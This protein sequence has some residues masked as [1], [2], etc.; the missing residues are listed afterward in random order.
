[1]R[2]FRDWGGSLVQRDV[3]PLSLTPIP[4][5]PRSFNNLSLI[6]DFV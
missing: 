5:R 3:C 1:M 4:L 2:F 6:T